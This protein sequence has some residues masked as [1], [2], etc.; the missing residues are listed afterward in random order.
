MQNESRKKQKPI[1]DDTNSC[2]TWLVTLGD[3]MSLMLCF[4]VMMLT[5]SDLESEQLTTM[6]GI[7][8][9]SL[10]VVQSEI[11]KQHPQATVNMEKV[12]EFSPVR[13]NFSALPQRLT[14]TQRRLSAQ[15]FKN[16]VT[17]EQLKYGLRVRIREDTLF[18]SA[19]DVTK[20]GA[21]ILLEVSNL[22]NDVSNEVRLLSTKTSNGAEDG[23]AYEKTSK[24]ANTLVEQGG[25][26]TERLGYGE[27][28]PTHGD[29]TAYFDIQLMDRVG[30][31]ELRFADLWKK[32]E[33]YR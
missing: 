17:I 10:N 2:P 31:Q 24:V 32:G 28:I 5:F 18:D 19:G 25:I 4:F 23:T 15:G 22:V 3:A 6:L 8:S 26:A 9:G 21:H 14:E 16:H 7:L 20:K 11:D 13:L 29:Q 1:L 30:L 12:E 27:R 33:D